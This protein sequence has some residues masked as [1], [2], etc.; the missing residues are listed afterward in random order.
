MV[1]S[2]TD[3]ETIIMYMDKDRKF[4]VGM[5]KSIRKANIRRIDRESLLDVLYGLFRKGFSDEDI[6]N[7]IK[8]SIQLYESND[9]K[10]EMRAISRE[11]DNVFAGRQP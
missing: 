3:K 10:K 9:F 2:K 5:E 8:M 4:F 11:I 6:A 1:N 7:M